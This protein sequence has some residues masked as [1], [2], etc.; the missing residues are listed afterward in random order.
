MPDARGQHDS[1]ESRSCE[2]G[3]SGVVVPV[4][5]KETSMALFHPLEETFV[6]DSTREEWV[7]RCAEALRTAPHFQDVASSA[8]LFRVS[9]RYRRPPVWGDIHVTLTQE[10]SGSTRITARAMAF[11]NLFA[12]IFSPE[13]RILD[14]FARTLT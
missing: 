2:A 4:S 10:G 13:R 1:A 5:R 11:P 12:L 3:A 7:K 6:V 8:E 14:Q 9:A